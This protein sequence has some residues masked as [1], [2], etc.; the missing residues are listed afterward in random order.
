[1]AGVAAI[2]RLKKPAKPAPAATVRA[3][4]LTAPVGESHDE[5]GLPTSTPMS[6]AW[7]A[8]IGQ[9]LQAEDHSALVAEHDRNPA[10]QAVPP[11]ARR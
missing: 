8:S 9:M 10:P 4:P 3:N 6:E 7:R 1:M 5:D 11:D 2:A